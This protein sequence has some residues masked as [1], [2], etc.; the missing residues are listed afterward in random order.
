VSTLIILSHTDDEVFLIPYLLA[1]KNENFALVYLAEIDRPL[2]V[3]ERVFSRSK[4]ALRVIKFLSSQ[5]HVDRCIF[6]EPGGRLQDGL[7]HLAEESQIQIIVNRL[8]Q[9]NEV[10]KVVSLELEGGHQ[11]H[12]IC[13]SIARVVA[14]SLQ[15]PHFTVPAHRASARWAAVPIPQVFVQNPKAKWLPASPFKVFAL[16]T[17]IV[18]QYRSQLPTW[19]VLYPMISWS[20][21]RRHFWIS[22]D[23]RF[24][25]IQRSLY[26]ARGKATTSSV[27]QRVTSILGSQSG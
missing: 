26:E 14:L 24:V 19:L 9:Q 22:Q 12:D 5:L 13:W 10:D 18:A 6:M 2:R 25:D 23:S 15:V 21:L 27:M 4:E 20:I 11:D 17:R 8:S 7:F 3:S 1:N 16:I